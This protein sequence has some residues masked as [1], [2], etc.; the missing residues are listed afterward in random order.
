[1]DYTSDI[2]WLLRIIHHSGWLLGPLR[3]RQTADRRRPDAHTADTCT[4]YSAARTALLYHTPLHDIARAAREHAARRRG[5]ALRPHIRHRGQRH[6]Y[7]SVQDTRTAT[8]IRFSAGTRR[9]ITGHTVRTLLTLS[10]RTDQVQGRRTININSG[11]LS[12]GAND[13]PRSGR[14]SQFQPASDPLPCRALLS[15]LT[16]PCLALPCLAL[17]CLA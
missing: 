9:R 7:G 3:S 1:M 13:K 16:L 17:P 10:L 2:A 8:H 11:S 14:S 12:R 6:T 5:F 15:S 4:G